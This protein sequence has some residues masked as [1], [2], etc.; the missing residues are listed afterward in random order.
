MIKLNDE[1]VPIMTRV[2]KRILLIFMFLV[3]FV[4]T[5]CTWR[6]IWELQYLYCY[7]NITNSKV[8]NQ[9]VLNTFYFTL[10]IFLLWKFELLACLSS[11][12]TCEDDYFRLKDNLILINNNFETFFHVPKKFLNRSEKKIHEFKQSIYTSISENDST[13]KMP[14][15]NV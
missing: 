13:I 2:V 1:Q 6:G 5:I 7:P 8:L 10:S 3:C 11:R 15:V 14:T 9:N 4:G 12:S